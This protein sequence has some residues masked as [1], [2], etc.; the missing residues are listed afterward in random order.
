MAVFHPP[1]SSTEEM[2]KALAELSA[3]KDAWLA[4]SVKERLAI[5]DV[6]ARNL[7]AVAERWVHFSAEAK[8]YGAGH[9]AEGDEWAMFAGVP[10][11]ILRLKEVLNDV[12]K[13][14]QPKLPG[15]FVTRNGQLTVQTF[16]LQSWEKS[17][18]ANYRADLWLEPG[19]SEAEALASQ[20]RIYKD[21][22]QR[23]TLALVLGAGNVSML[24]PC[25]ITSKL[26]LENQVVLLKMNPVND[27]LGPLIEEA[28]RPLIERG[29][30]KLVYGG[31]KEGAYLCQHEAVDVIHMTGS[32][33][34]Y[35]AIVFGSRENKQARQPLITKP[36]TAELGGV[37]PLIVVPGDWTEAEIYEQAKQVAFWLV[38]NAGFNCLSPRVIIT[39]KGWALREAFLDAV[40]SALGEYL[41]RKA[42]YPNA[43]RFYDEFTSAHANARQIGQAGEGELPWTLIRDLDPTNKD[44]I[45]FRSEAF[46]G[47]FTETALDAADAGEFIHKAVTFANET[48]WGNLAAYILVSDASQTDAAVSAA[49]EQGIADLKYG[50]VCVNLFA[51]L[52]YVF[53]SAPWGAYPGNSIYDV[54]SGIGNVNNLFMFE[55]VQ[56]GVYRAPFK[57]Q[58]DTTTNTPVYVASTRAIAGLFGKPS[59][60]NIVRL[61]LASMKK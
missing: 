25:D 51:G 43:K 53:S 19:V 17:I 21:K 59:F 11:N 26:F 10:R 42:Y 56:K 8:G 40:E 20:A 5:L 24:V 13:H 44:D 30:L 27:Y 16:P 57:K 54:Q 47:L 60:M 14:G 23:G 32:D 37:N 18:F 50:T 36:V 39:H 1:A 48:L 29:F 49:L 15:G 52:T 31:A 38:V 28:Y 58:P 2:N 7:N 6:I 34:T 9:A 35:D 41:V 45:A 22:Q 33:K 4:V 61:I 55:K 46:C 3:K 12:M